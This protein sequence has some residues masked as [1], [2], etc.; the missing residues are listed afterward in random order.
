[1]LCSTVTSVKRTWDPS[2]YAFQKNMPMYTVCSP[3]FKLRV[4]SGKW[5]YMLKLSNDMAIEQD[6]QVSEH[7]P[8]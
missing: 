7:M 1:V 6:Y 8:G 2:K 5:Q 4:F 3:H